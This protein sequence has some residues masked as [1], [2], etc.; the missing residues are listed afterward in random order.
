MKEQIKEKEDEDNLRDYINVVLKRKK[1]IISILLI[2][3]IT[4][5][6]VL[7][8]M[9]K[10]Y[11]A[12]TQIMITPSSLERT[13]DPTQLSLDISRTKEGEYTSG[14]PTM[15]IETHKSLLLSNLILAKISEKVKSPK[16]EKVTL[17]SLRKC[18]DIEEV[19]K[20]S[21]IELK[22]KNKEPNMAKEIA[23]I[24]AN[25]YFEYNRQ[26]LSGE[27]KGSGEFIM[28]QFNLTRKEMEAQEDEIEAF[29]KKNNIDLMKQ[30]LE[31]QKT[32]LNDYKKELAG[33]ELNIKTQEDNLKECKTQ[34]A[35]QDR[36]ILVSKAITDEAL[37]KRVLEESPEQKDLKELDELKLRSQVLNPIYQYLEAKIVN[38][39]IALNTLKAK[40]KYLED[41]TNILEPK[42]IKLM[43]KIREKEKELGRLNRK[44]NLK[45]EIYNT[46]STKLN[47]IRIAKA[48]EIGEVRI[49]SPAVTPEKPIGPKKRQAIAISGI[50]SFMFGIFAAFFLELIQRLKEKEK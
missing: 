25:E 42:V 21:I 50:L 13:L 17:E 35:T 49:A 8:L 39:K 19:K 48:A 27:I 12:I 6:V 1:I 22:V 40:Q 38:T 36:Y 20:T 5:A 32:K 2:P 16:D 7:L 44:L 23:N 9:P 34:I 11:Q 28:D 45:N 33:L 31:I 30:E 47:E 14:R 41:E 18:L 43:N 10:I 46:L 15:S 24:W 29:L 4:T 26:L 3:T 37:W